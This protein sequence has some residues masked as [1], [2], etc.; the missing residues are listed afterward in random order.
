MVPFG[1][2][3]V[4]GFGGVLPRGELFA[5][6]VFARIPLPPETAEMFKPLALSVKLA[7]LPFANGPL[8]DE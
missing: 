3:S 1:V 2:R 5:V 6:I 7:I 4:L 8:F